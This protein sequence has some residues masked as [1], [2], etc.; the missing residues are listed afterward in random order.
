MCGVSLK[1]LREEGVAPASLFGHLE[2]VSII[3]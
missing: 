2:E 1:K 3:C